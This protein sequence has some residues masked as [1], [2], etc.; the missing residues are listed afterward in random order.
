MKKVL[1]S[2]L[3]LSSVLLFSCTKEKDWLEVAGNGSAPATS[4]GYSL[5]EPL[6]L[7]IIPGGSATFDTTINVFYSGSGNGAIDVNVK[8]DPSVVDA[9][10]LANG[11]AIPVAPDNTF[12]IPSSFS[13]PAGSHVGS[14]DLSIN[15]DELLNNG[16]QFAIGLTITDAGAQASGKSMI[17]LITA[18]NAYDGLYTLTGATA[19]P[20]NPVLTG[21]VGPY[22]DVPLLTVSANAVIL[23]IAHPWANG[24]G[25][26][27]PGGYEPTYTIHDDN[28]VTV[29]NTAIGEHEDPTY[30]NHYDP[31]TKTIYA[32]WMYTSTG[33]DRVFTDTLVYTG[34]R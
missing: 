34:P 6:S 30:D 29:T 10:N 12:T 2:F 13:I 18:R 28:S 17:V 22:T 5:A 3:L 24:S 11:T 14:G 19:H 20:T 4:F 25:S 33:G 8:V 15:I 16:V 31:A 23:G 1:S 7:D 21:P 27:L 9:Y 26:A 32:Q